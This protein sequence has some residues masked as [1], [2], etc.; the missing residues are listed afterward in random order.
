MDGMQTDQLSEQPTQME[1]DLSTT[2]AAM[3]A[4]AFLREVIDRGELSQMSPGT[5]HTYASMMAQNPY[6]VVDAFGMKPPTKKPLSSSS[7]Y[8]FFMDKYTQASLTDA[9]RTVIEDQ[10][11]EDLKAYE[12]WIGALSSVSPT[13]N[14]DVI[15]SVMFAND[16]AIKKLEHDLY[17]S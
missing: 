1:H 11:Q 6:A 12:D 7:V 14:T 9:V 10:K 5:M 4:S 16:E 3:Q 2:D 15:N 17:Y 8:D 13:G